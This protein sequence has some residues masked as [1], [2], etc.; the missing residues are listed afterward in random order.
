[1][2]PPEI[3]LIPVFVNVLIIDAACVEIP[4]SDDEP[5]LGNGIKS[6]WCLIAFST[7]SPNDLNLTNKIFITEK[8]ETCKM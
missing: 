8:K 6:S 1:M 3:T 4:D 7:D 5:G 2:S